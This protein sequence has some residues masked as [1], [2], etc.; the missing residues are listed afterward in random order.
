MFRPTVT[1]LAVILSGSAATVWA[2]ALDHKPGGGITVLPAPGGAPAATVPNLNPAP[3]HAPGSSSGSNIF[4]TPAPPSPPRAQPAPRT[5]RPG[6]RPTDENTFSDRI[7]GDDEPTRSN[8][9]KDDN[10]H[11]HLIPYKY[12]KHNG[13]GLYRPWTFNPQ[14]NYWYGRDY[15]AYV[16]GQPDRY[17]PIM[18]PQGWYPSLNRPVAGLPT[19]AMY[20]QTDNPAR[21]SA[22]ISGNTIGIPEPV[23]VSPL[24]P[25][26]QI[27][28][29]V[30]PS[31]ITPP[32]APT[33]PTPTITPIPVPTFP[34]YR[35]SMSDTMADPY[36][37]P[38]GNR[39]LAQYPATMYQHGI[40][41]PGFDAVS[42]TPRHAGTYS[43]YVGYYGFGNRFNYGY[44]PYNYEWSG[45]Y[46]GFGRTGS[47]NYHI[48]SSGLQF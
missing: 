24:R 2:Q 27:P 11:D 8:R 38:Y 43:P 42:Y 6:V 34:G 41:P 45:G 29:M 46:S 18:T 23:P 30:N 35:S 36:S 4:V 13:V 14:Y 39:Y 48:W 7:P 40:H 47:F 31:A 16:P 3:I 15:R 10:P 5:N 19:E 9:K 37:N 44:G 28:P 33:M 21:L 1:A 20:G 25:L 12:S 17:S 32:I 22:P 26:S